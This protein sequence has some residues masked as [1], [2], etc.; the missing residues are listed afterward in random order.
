M[1]GTVKRECIREK[2][3]GTV[4]ETRWYVGDYVKHYSMGRLHSTIGYVTPQ[5][6]LEGRALET[7]QAR[8]QKLEAARELRKQG[9]RG[10][11]LDERRRP[12]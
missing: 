10:E 9:D 11:L 5:A 8:D 12:S 1:Q 2:N 6:M 3:P 4:E 7:H